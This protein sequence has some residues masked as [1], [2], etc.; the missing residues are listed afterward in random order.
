MLDCNDQYCSVHKGE[1]VDLY[2]SVVNACITASDHIPTTSPSTAKVI[3]RWNDGAKYSRDEALSWHHFWKINGR[4]G[5][6]YIAEMHQISTAR[7]HRSIMHIQR[8]KKIIQSE[9]MA[10]ALMSNNSRDV[11]SEVRKVKGRNSKISSNADGSC[12]SK[13]ITDLFFEKYTHLYNSVPYNIDDMHAIESAI[14]VRLHNCGN[15]KY[16]ITAVSQLKKCKLDGSEGFFS[17]H[18]LRATHLFYVILSILFNLF[19]QHGFSTDLII[20]GTM[21]P[22]PKNR[23][24]SLWEKKLV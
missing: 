1:I 15:V 18:F 11:W 20:M 4:P 21:I 10:H 5:A 13:E 14:F 24:Q 17:D 6:G 2:K 3:P 19:L 23:K 22:I 12:D 8:N 16:V 9:K 7:Y